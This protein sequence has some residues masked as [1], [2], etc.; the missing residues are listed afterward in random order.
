MRMLTPSKMVTNLYQRLY[1]FGHWVGSPAKIADTP[2]EFSAILRTQIRAIS[3]DSWWE[4]YLQASADDVQGLSQ[5]YVRTIY[6]SHPLAHDEIRQ[7]ISSWQR[8]RYRLL[9]VKILY[10]W[11]Y[12]IRG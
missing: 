10:M 9:L 1:R 7:T 12:R 8:L 2:S 6:S 11:R 3:K 5:T 4:P